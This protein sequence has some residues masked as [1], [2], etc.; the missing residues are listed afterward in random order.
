MI[1]KG[2]ECSGIINIDNTLIR[3]YSELTLKGELITI[4]NERNKIMALVDGSSWFSK[5]N[6]L[7]ADCL[8]YDWAKEQALRV[9][10]VVA[11]HRN[12]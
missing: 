4:Q 12:M 10:K 1:T 7:Q 8:N 9:Y 5:V 3:W 11:E 2:S 6:L